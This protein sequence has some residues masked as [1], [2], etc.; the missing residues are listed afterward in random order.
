M[1][2]LK[3]ILSSLTFI[4]ILFEYIFFLISPVYSSCLSPAVPHKITAVS[5]TQLAASS[6]PKNNISL[7]ARYAALIDADNNRL[8]YGKEADIKAPNASTT[9]IITLITALNICADDYIA[10]TSAYAASMPDVQLNAIKGEQFT[11]KDLYFSLMLRSHNDTAVIIAENAAYYYICNLSDK[12]RNELIYDISFIPDYSN[13]SSF[14]KN[15][16]KEQSKVLVRIFTDLM[17]K[18]ALEAGC[19][20]THFVTPNGLDASDENGIHQ[21]TAYDLSVMMSYC[22]KNP[23]FIEITKSSSYSF[24]NLDGKRYSVTNA[25]AFLSMYDNIISGKTGFTADAGYCYVCAYKDENKTFVVALLACGWPNNKSYK[26]TDSKVLLDYARNNFEK[27]VLLD[28]IKT[29]NVKVTNGTSDDINVVIDKKYS[30]Y[31]KSDDEVKI[32]YNIPDSIMAPVKKND[33]IGTVTV[34][35]NNEAVKQYNIISDKDINKCEYVRKVSYIIRH[36]LYFLCI[37]IQ[38]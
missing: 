38:F 15:I 17:N 20:N 22:I 28:N 29:F 25:N 9:K 24:S 19:T 16:S 10:T 31:V 18:K 27:Q 5:K 21:T 11:I 1:K 12:E 14:L 30:A 26:W 6:S 37:L 23:D 4:V 8:L 3:Y 7:H 34:Y 2:P 35:I 13:N 32:E 33:V 36:F